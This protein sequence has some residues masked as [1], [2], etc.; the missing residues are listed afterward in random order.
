MTMITEIT[1]HTKV[2]DLLKVFPQLEDKLIEISP[3]FA[4][5][6]NPILRRTVAKVAT[7]RQIAE[8]AK[9][10]PAELINTLR[11][12]VGLSP[13]SDI[14]STDISSSPPPWAEDKNVVQTIDVRPLIEQGEHPKEHV[15]KQSAK[16]SSGE[17]LQL[18]TPFKPAPLMDILRQRGF[19]VWADDHRC[20]I[21][22]P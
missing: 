10:N 5:L 19:Q 3:T 4:K 18:L 12:E 16:L 14:E 2:A 17:V 13:L 6:K 11:Q 9:L 20:F 15:L 21:Y 8:V 22:K 7:I 1:L